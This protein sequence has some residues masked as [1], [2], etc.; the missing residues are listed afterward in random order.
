MNIKKM[1]R[2]AQEQ[3]AKIQEELETLSVEGTAGGG[4]VVVTLNGH[5]QMLSLKLDPQVIDPEEP[6]ML[7]DLIVAAT[8]DASRRADELT[9][10]KLGGMLG[11]LGAG[12]PG[13]GD[14]LG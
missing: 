14:L 13:L 10:E 6:E 8:A 9:Q 3:Q 1:M 5:K 11:G 12:I 7:Q 2:Q 4:M